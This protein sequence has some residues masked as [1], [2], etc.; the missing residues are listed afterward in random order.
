MA[1]DWEVE[2]NNRA[3]VPEHPEI[4]ARWQR[5]AAAYRDETGKQG[6]AELGIKYGPSVRQTVDLFMPAGSGANAP[7][8]MFVHGGYWRSLEPSTFS[9]TARGMN[10]HGITVAVIGYDLVPQVTIGKIVE[11]TQAAC[12]QLWK[13]FGRR[14]MVSGHSAGGQLAACMVATDWKKHGAPA[15]LVPAAYAI[16]GLYD[17]TVLTHLSGN[18]EFKLTEAS[19]REISPLFW[20]APKG[21]VFDSVV[22]GIESSEF[23]RQSKIIADAWAKDNAT[24]YEAVPGMNHFTVCDAMADPD[25][26]MTKRLVELAGRV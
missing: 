3:R 18:A 15:D 26:A 24:R 9:Q 17:L 7:L 16:S 1:I 21:K 12:L 19:A 22:G 2:Y 6:R 10:A 5:E 20:P 25:S 13:R 4:F 8:A 14:I 23:L 11:Q